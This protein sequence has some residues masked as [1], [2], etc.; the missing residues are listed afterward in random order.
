[1]D[2]GLPF[3]EINGV[4]SKDQVA[5]FVGPGFKKEILV[6]GEPVVM[7]ELQKME[8]AGTKRPKGFGISGRAAIEAEDNAPKMAD[9][10]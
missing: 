3:C 10:R 6:W 1:M 7:E 4:D 9:I 5:A 8:P 2:Q